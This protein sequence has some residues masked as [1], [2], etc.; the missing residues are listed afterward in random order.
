MCVFSGLR[1]RP[2]GNRAAAVWVQDRSSALAERRS[3]LASRRRV[4]HRRLLKRVS[5]VDAKDTRFKLLSSIPRQVCQLRIKVALQDLRAP[6]AQRL[7]QLTVASA[8]TRQLA[9]TGA[10]DSIFRCPWFFH[11]LCNMLA[12]G[13]ARRL[14]PSRTRSRP[15][16]YWRRPA[17]PTGRDSP[18]QR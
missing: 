1:I 17:P 9:G 6:L 10:D 3:L 11:V 8:D 12:R 16:R 13:E 18:D 4:F 2:D 5:A 7:R 14:R 15:A